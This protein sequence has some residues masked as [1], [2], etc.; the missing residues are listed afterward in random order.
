[1]YVCTY[2]RT[3]VRMYILYIYIYIHMYVTR[4]GMHYC[5]PAPYNSSKPQRSDTHRDFEG[6]PNDGPPHDRLLC[7]YLALFSKVLY[8]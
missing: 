2:V 5:Y 3:Y 7:S 1:M 4:N 8:K 6:P